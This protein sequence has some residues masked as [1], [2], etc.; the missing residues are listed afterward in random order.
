MVFVFKTNVKEEQ[1]DKVNSLLSPVKSIEEWN[2]DLSDCDRILRV[3]ADKLPPELVVYL[4][5]G[6][7]LYCTELED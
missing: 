6:S 2:F 4:L 3:V 5:Q 1:V 7:G